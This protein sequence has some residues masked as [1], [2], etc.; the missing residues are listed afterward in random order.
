MRADV[1]RCK[2]S[3]GNPVPQ[4]EIQHMSFCENL[5]VCCTKLCRTVTCWEH[6]PDTLTHNYHVFRLRYWGQQLPSTQTT[7]RSFSRQLRK[8]IFPI[9]SL[10]LREWTQ[11]RFVQKPVVELM[12][13][14]TFVETVMR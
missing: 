4:G 2:V 3:L 13:I 10:H 9:E 11:T 7:S 8:R 12:E 1:H 14:S 5:R 6:D